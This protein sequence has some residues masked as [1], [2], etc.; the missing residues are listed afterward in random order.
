L[1]RDKTIQL[2]E[3]EVINN[4]IVSI[5]PQIEE[6]LKQLRL[7]HWTLSLAESCTGGLFSSLI[8]Q[9]SGVSDVFMGALV[10][11]ANSAKENIL[12]VPVK[13]IEQYGAVSEEVA[14]EMARGAKRV[15][16]TDV[17]VAVTGVAGPS[18]GTKDKPVGLVCFALSGP[19]FERSLHNQ[20]SGTRNEIQAASVSWILSIFLKELKIG[21]K[22]EN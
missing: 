15:F 9:Q 12:G 14:V 16:K 17:S 1:V 18:G 11:Y 3:R 21:F 5:T 7:C 13:T 6:L 2:T 4:L 8:T 20:F 22:R 10:A 19:S